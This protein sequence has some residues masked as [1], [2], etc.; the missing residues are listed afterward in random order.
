MNTSLRNRGRAAE[1]AA[2]EEEIAM[3]TPEPRGRNV[4]MLA[5]TSNRRWMQG[6][7]G[8]GAMER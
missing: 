5:W 4:E 3:G 2:I 7:Y 8:N 1:V 6:T